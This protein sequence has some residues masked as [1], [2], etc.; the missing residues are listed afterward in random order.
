MQRWRFC[1]KS[2]AYAMGGGFKLSLKDGIW[3]GKIMQ[4]RTGVMVGGR[5]IFWEC[6]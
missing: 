6:F 4:I 5:K 1:E 2:W 3:R